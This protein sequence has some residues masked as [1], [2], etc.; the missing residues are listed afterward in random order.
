LLVPYTTLFRSSTSPKRFER[1]VIYHLDQ[2]ELGIYSFAIKMSRAH[3][4]AQLKEVR[5]IRFAIK[6]KMRFQQVYLNLMTCQFHKSHFD[7]NQYYDRLYLS[8][9]H[10]LQMLG[11]FLKWISLLLS[12]NRSLHRLDRKSTRLNSSHVSISYAVFCCPHLVLSTRSALSPY[13]TLFRS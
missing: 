8:F 9:Q 11:L 3:V 1:I 13:T 4:N 6:M 5:N 2:L 10:W 12:I 7:I